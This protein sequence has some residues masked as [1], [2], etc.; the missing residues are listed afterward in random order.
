VLRPADVDRGRALR[1]VLG[2]V[3]VRPRRRVQCQPDAEVGDER[4]GRVRD[5]PL[6]EID[7]E[8]I[9]VQLGQSMPQLARRAGDQDAAA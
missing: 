3:D 4:R 8:R 2:T 6:V 7:G 9:R 5:V 1:V